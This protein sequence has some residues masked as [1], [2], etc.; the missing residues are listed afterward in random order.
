MSPVILHIYR[1]LLTDAYGF[2]PLRF[3]K[4]D[5]DRLMVVWHKD[6]YTQHCNPNDSY[7]ELM[8]RYII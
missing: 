4:A 3:Y 1:E 6:E 2:G 8:K 7:Y 5:D